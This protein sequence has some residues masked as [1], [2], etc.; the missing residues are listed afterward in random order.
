MRFPSDDGL[1]LCRNFIQGQKYN[2]DE[3]SVKYPKLEHAVQHAPPASGLF[4][5]G[6]RE[7]GEMF[8][9]LQRHFTRRF[10]HMWHGEESQREEPREEDDHGLHIQLCRS[11][12]DWS[13]GK[14]TEHSIANA[15]IEAIT[16]AQKFVY[17][18]N[19]VSRLADA[20]L[21]PAFH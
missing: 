19:Q 17:I 8:G 4:E 7:T 9:G 15:Y 2:T 18:E 10:G 11:C 6:Q 20:H 21:Y 5:E 14:P 16:N 12:T 1:T 13:G 3:L